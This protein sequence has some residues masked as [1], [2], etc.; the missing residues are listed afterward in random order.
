MLGVHGCRAT[1]LG[2]HSFLLTWKTDK[3]KLVDI[4]N[5]NNS[6]FQWTVDPVNP[7]FHG[8]RWQHWGALLNEKRTERATFEERKWS[9][10]TNEMPGLTEWPYG[11]SPIIPLAF[12]TRTYSAKIWQTL[13]HKLNVQG[14]LFVCNNNYSRL[15]PSVSFANSRLFC[16]CK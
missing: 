16:L 13:H 14:S 5:G 4:S 1:L 7:A 11:T 6:V 10:C 12:A 3:I 9:S 8:G 2:L 15:D